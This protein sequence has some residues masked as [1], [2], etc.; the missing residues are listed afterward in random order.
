[1]LISPYFLEVVNGILLV[2]YLSLGY[3]FAAYIVRQLFAG[4]WGW[5]ETSG[6]AA[7]ML[8]LMIGEAL[9]R[10]AVW[11]PRHLLNQNQP[12]TH[13]TTITTSLLAV[14]TL[15]AIWGGICM[16]RQFVPPRFR[17]WAPVCAVA[18]ALLFGIGMAI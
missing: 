15:L 3:V 8:I 13:L 2:I 16:I 1:M 14:G 4:R 12:I 18:A 6:A 5:N 9:I 10:V 17:I 11:I 7:A